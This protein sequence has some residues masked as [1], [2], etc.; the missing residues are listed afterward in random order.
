MLR[1][2]ISTVLGD[3]FDQQNIFFKTTNV[4]GRDMVLI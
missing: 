2:K 1:M 3:D 4:I